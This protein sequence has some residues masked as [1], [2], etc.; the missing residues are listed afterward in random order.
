MISTPVVVAVSILAFS[1]CLF[2]VV[3]RV[4][5]GAADKKTSPVV[6]YKRIKPVIIMSIYSFILGTSAIIG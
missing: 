1:T 2:H 4:L 6:L 3:S 5:E